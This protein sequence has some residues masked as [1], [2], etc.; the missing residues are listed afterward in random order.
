MNISLFF[1][2]AFDFLMK[3]LDDLVLDTPDAPTILGNFMARAIADDCIP[4][5][6]ILSYK[7]HVDTELA[8]KSLCRAGNFFSRIKPH[9]IQL[10]GQF[11][12]E[13]VF[14]FQF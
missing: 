14:I 8:G 12:H 7:G 6:F 3:N 4:P 9:Q 1:L 11:F 10:F 2:S 5:K 13:I